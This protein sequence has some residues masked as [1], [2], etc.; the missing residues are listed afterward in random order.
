MKVSV[1][2]IEKCKVL[3]VTVFFLGTAVVLLNDKLKCNYCKGLVTCS[4]RRICL[5]IMNY[6][7]GI[8]RG[9]LMH[10]DPTTGVASTVVY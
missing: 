3:L 1:S 8:G 9:P 5:K 4:T 7:D 10:P 2:D 6:I